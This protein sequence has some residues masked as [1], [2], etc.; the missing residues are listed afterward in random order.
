MAELK[1][2]LQL[3]YEETLRENEMLHAENALKLTQILG[4]EQLLY[5]LRGYS[6]DK[7]DDPCWLYNDV[8]GE[9]R[10]DDDGTVYHAPECIKARQATE[11]FWKGIKT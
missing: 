3:Q 8:S 6:G 10:I 2:L 5:D 9:C 11:P 4:L 7:E 1:T